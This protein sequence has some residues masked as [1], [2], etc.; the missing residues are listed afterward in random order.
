MEVFVFTQ[1]GK[2]SGSKSKKL[3]VTV[4][5]LAA[6]AFSLNF[7][8]KSRYNNL[9]VAILFGTRAAANFSES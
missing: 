2:N 3:R 9:F 7:K 8:E 6:G 5:G 4:F 1:C